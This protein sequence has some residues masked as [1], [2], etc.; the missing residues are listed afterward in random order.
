MSLPQ[1]APLAHR[2]PLVIPCLDRFQVEAA[3]CRQLSGW[4]E[5]SRR[6]FL[7]I[8]IPTRRLDQLATDTGL[9]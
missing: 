1:A 9:K 6:N 7:P 2:S 3:A 5:D 8:P 4:G